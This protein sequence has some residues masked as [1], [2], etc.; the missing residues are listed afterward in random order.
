MKT[1]KLLFFTVA[2]CL[3]GFF[4]TF[5]QTSNYDPDGT[6]WGE[7]VHSVYVDFTQF[8]KEALPNPINTTD[9]IM[10]LANL[11]IKRW[12]IE[13]RPTMEENNQ[14]TG[15]SVNC[16]FNN[17]LNSDYNAIIYFP[18]LKDGV[19]KIRIRGWV[20]GAITGRGVGLSYWNENFS[21][22]GADWSYIT[23]I[24]IPGDGSNVVEYDLNREGPINLRL[25]YGNTSY[26]IITSIAISAFGEEI[27]ETPISGIANVNKEQL[28][29]VENTLFLDNEPS[30]VFFYNFDGQQ[31][32]HK[33]GVSG[34]VF[35][36]ETPGIV[37]V[38]KNSKTLV[39]KKL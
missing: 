2:L 15:P 28:T 3:C 21:D 14:Q 10:E 25:T 12:C 23:G 29:I 24:I 6:Y 7:S 1:K 35:L 5:A 18:T 9:S 13:N 4:N 19:G 27:V 20:T 34:N 30:E 38:I 26:M 8:S 37:K 33:K 31:V 22:E 36:P 32:L 17:G 39:A 16:L 11:G